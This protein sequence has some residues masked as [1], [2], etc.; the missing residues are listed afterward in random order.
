MRNDANCRH[1]S[2]PKSEVIDSKGKTQ[3]ALSFSLEGT[4]RDNVA[5]IAEL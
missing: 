1:T 5:S 3:R 2:S 4:G